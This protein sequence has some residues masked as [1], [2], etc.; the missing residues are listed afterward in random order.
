MTTTRYYTQVGTGYA[1]EV[2]VALRSDWK[3]DN[4]FFGALKRGRISTVR[5]GDIPALSGQNS[6][7]HTPPSDVINSQLVGPANLAA[8]VLA[9]SFRMVAWCSTQYPNPPWR[10][11]LRVVSSDGAT[12]RGTVFDG[13]SSEVWT[14]PAVRIVEGSLSPLMVQAN[15]RLVLEVGHRIGGTNYESATAVGS[16]GSS[17]DLVYARRGDY[18]GVD[19]ASWFELTTPS[20][21]EVPTSLAVELTSPTA[22]NATWSPAA[23]ATGYDYR[24]DSGSPVGVAGPSAELTG[25]AGDTP[26]TI[27]VRAV[28]AHAYLTWADDPTATSYDV[29]VDSGAWVPAQSRTS[30]ALD[31]YRDGDGHTFAV[32]ANHNA[33]TITGTATVTSATSNKSSPA[34]ETPDRAVDGN[35]GTKWLSLDPNCALT[36]ALPAP[37]LVVAYRLAS[38][39]DDDT[40]DPKTWSLQGSNDGVNWSTLD[41]R[42]DEPKWPS[43]G[44]YRDYDVF[45]PGTFSSYRWQIGAVHGSSLMQIAE[46]VLRTGTVASEPVPVAHSVLY[47]EVVSAWSDPVG[48]STG[49]GPPPPPPGSYTTHLRVGAHSWDVSSDDEADYG[50]LAGLRFFWDARQDDGWPTQHNPTGLVF[51]IVVEAGIDFSDVDQ[52]TAVHFTFTPA[53]LDAPL[54][55]FGGTVRDLS[56]TPHPLGMVYAITAMDPLVALQEVHRVQVAIPANGD[57][58]GPDGLWARATSDTD[59]YG[60]RPWVP[61]PFTGD[62][63]PADFPGSTNGLTPLDM[64]DTAWAVWGGILASFPHKPGGPAYGQHRGVL[65]YNL[66][67]EGNLDADQP[68]EGTWVARPTTDSPVVVPGS[69]LPTGN[70]SWSRPRIEP[71][72]VAVTDAVLG[73]LPAVERPHTGVDVVRRMTFTPGTY[74]GFTDPLWVV[75][76]TESDDQWSTGLVLAAA[77]DPELVAGWF[78]LPTAMRVFVRCEGVDPRHT[79][80]GSGELVGLLA[81]A[82]LVIPPRGDWFVSFTLRKTLP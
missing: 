16:G 3:T 35:V 30:H 38:A 73:E 65:T 80:T 18:T 24:L 47:S 34:G 9:G 46:V 43:R 58:G 72:V 57:M 45:Q 81:G 77:R 28:G 13:T 15:D 31:G 1:P 26:Y 7:T 29:R 37:A 64:Q 75:A 33:T 17:P 6:G 69:L 36:M 40:R 41:T 60:P 39:N 20:A 55:T 11:V 70:T 23:G 49:E 78:T 25:L 67:A 21:P 5:A 32:R 42:V 59:G 66:D 27:Q 22:A 68:Y 54:V 63:K 52:G 79:P 19:G 82:S 8:G 4:L 44:L 62:V 51:G 10:V 61:D 53:E 50:P 56:A 74:V 48:F 71:N 14:Q 76:G 2:T 12:V